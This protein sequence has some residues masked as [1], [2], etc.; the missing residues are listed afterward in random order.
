MNVF[1]VYTGRTGCMCGCNGQYSYTNDGVA[2]E[3]VNPEYVSVDEDS[4]RA[5]A[6]RVLSHPKVQLQGKQAFVEDQG[7]IDMVFFA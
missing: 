4:V 5:I 7:T 3:G 2:L 6:A 1:K